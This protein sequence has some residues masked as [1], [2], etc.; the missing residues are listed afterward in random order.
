M[1]VG[2]VSASYQ[3]E[4]PY[5]INMDKE[6]AD[7]IVNALV[8]KAKEKLNGGK[9]RECMNFLRSADEITNLFEVIKKEEEKEDA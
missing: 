8:L 6:L 7:M 4:A 2:Y 5:R 9:V 3:D 1:R